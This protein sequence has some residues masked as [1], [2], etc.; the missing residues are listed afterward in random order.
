M[1]G[2][3]TFCIAGPK[4]WNLLLLVIR[5]ETDTVKFKAVLKTF[6]FDGSANILQKIKER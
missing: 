3:G 1:Y 6:L 2:D 5:M 4:L